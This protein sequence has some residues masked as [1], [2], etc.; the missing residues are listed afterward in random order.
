MIGKDLAEFP[1]TFEEAKRLGMAELHQQRRFPVDLETWNDKE[2]SYNSENVREG[3][4]FNF[5]SMQDNNQNKEKVS[6][7]EITLSPLVCFL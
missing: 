4:Q 3:G 6:L 1:L 2:L 5:E 7:A